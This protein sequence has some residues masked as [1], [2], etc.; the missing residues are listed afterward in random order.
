MD[1]G[2]SAEKQY[3]RLWKIPVL[4]LIS[5]IVIT[6][7]C[8]ALLQFNTD[9]IPVIQL[10]HTDNIY[11]TY[12]EIDNAG[13]RV[14]IEPVFGRS[15]VIEGF[16][17]FEIPDIPSDPAPDEGFEGLRFRIGFSRI[18]FE[19]LDQ[20][21]L[22]FN[23]Q[24]DVW[25]I[26]FLDDAVLYSDFPDPDYALGAVFDNSAQTQITRDFAQKV[27]INLPF[28]FTGK[29]ITVIEFITPEHALLWNPTVLQLE[30]HEA[31]SLFSVM[32]YGPGS[33][34]AGCIGIIVILLIVLLAFQVQSG[35]NF[36]WLL[37]LPVVYG[38][39]FMLRVAFVEVFVGSQFWR[40]YDP[41]DFLNGFTYFCGSNLLLIFIAFRS[42]HRIKYILLAV[43]A[44]QLSI[45]AWHLIY[46]YVIYG[47]TYIGYEYVHDMTW[48]AIFGS[49]CIAFT[50]VLMMLERKNNRYFKQSIWVIFAFLTGYSLMI[51][52]SFLSNSGLFAVLIEPFTAIGDLNL[53]PLNNT[54]YLLVLLAIVV[55]STDEWLTEMAELRLNL[56]ALDLTN[57][58]KTEFLKN[59]SF[60]LKTPLTSVS[61]LSKHSYT[62][63]TDD[64]EQDND[65]IDEIHDNLRI[66][67]VESDRIKRVVDGLLN[68]AAI[69]QNEFELHK[70]YFSVPDLIQ[71]IGAVQFKAINTNGN[72]LKFSFAPDL[73]RINADRDR[74]QEVLL[75]LL[76]NAAQHTREG[77][78]IV[79]VKQNKKRILLSVSDNGEGIPEELKDKLFKRFLDADIG[80]AYGTGL[81]LYF[82]KQIIELHG[83]SIRLESKPGA[84]TTVY[85]DLPIDGAK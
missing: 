64:W 37:V 6:G 75:N 57:Q 25:Y 27:S 8:F 69:E 48:L 1:I 11:T 55:L 12:F 82:C 16:R 5:A 77:T 14:E 3:M 44:L 7:I 56:N 68:V 63:M 35:N 32:T 20:A 62:T 45:T 58:M 73:Q 78:I 81:G 70:D 42:N 26:I 54:L 59:I 51:F 24:G 71:E 21:Q 47:Y 76:S 29:T 34:L 30:T 84:G 28:D 15:G 10:T 83:G 46:N 43:S 65:S 50:F 53:Y 66:I 74:F 79:T 40:L 9:R 41:I 18:L 22:T 60:E 4:V 13:N 33:F 72:T 23:I 17:G 80:R 39:L 38:I 52:V 85:I 61:V 67:T 2:N 49:A 36:R 31:D 19:R